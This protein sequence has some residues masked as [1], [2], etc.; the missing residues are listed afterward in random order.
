M[1]NKMKRIS[2]P[3]SSVVGFPTLA[4]FVGILI[5]FQVSFAE[6]ACVICHTEMTPE[7]VEAFLAEDVH[8]GE[9]SCAGCHG[10]NPDA[11]P[12]D[13]DA[14]HEVDSFKAPPWS[15]QT[16][17]DRCG[18]CHTVELDTYMTGP[19]GKAL[20][21]GKN[22]LPGCIGCHTQHPLHKVNGKNSPVQPSRVPQTCGKCHADQVMMTAHDLPF[23]VVR[24]YRNSV[25][26]NALLDQ[27]NSEAP[28]C[29]GCHDNH[30]I[31]HENVSTFDEAC[32]RCHTFEAD[33]FK[34]SKHQRIWELTEAPVCI[35]CHGNHDINKAGTHM[36]GTEESAVCSKCHNPGDPPDE[37]RNLLNSLEEEFARGQTVITK[38]HKAHRNVDNEIEALKA[39]YEQ[40]VKA[41]KSVH[42]F[43]IKRI[44]REVEKGLELSKKV[45]LSIE[46]LLTESSCVTCHTELDDEMIHS[47]DGD[48]HSDKDISCHGCHG[49]NPLIEDEDAMSE[50]E[51][52]I[53]IPERPGDVGKFCSRCHSDPE[54]MGKFNPSIGTDQYAQFQKSGHGQTLKRNPHDKNVANCLKCHGLH[55]I[56]SVNDPLSKVYPTNVPETC[57]Q[58]H[59]N[60]EIMNQ[61]GIHIDP[62]QEYKTSVHG[63]A[64]L[65]NGDI[66][67][68]ACNDCH[69]NHGALPP[70]VGSVSNVCGQCHVINATMFKE[71]IHRGI[72]ELRGMQQCSSC[73]GS[74]AIFHPTDEMLSTKDGSFCSTCH[75]TGGPPDQ[76]HH[77][78]DTLSTS[79]KMAEGKLKLAE[80]YLIGV[81][82][83]YVM[84]DKAKTEL[85]K[86]RVL[87]HNFDMDTLNAVSANTMEIINDVNETGDEG[88]LKAKYRRRGFWIAFVIFIS[89]NIAIILKIRELNKKRKN[90]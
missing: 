83:G 86:M 64:L 17:V 34:S 5:L 33:A 52:F 13:M 21:E 57:N 1:E 62:Y 4:I 60:S 82:E 81:D 79:I 42:Y 6:D 80:S 9:Q 7:I 18:K 78:L 40:L 44:R 41:R 75:Q 47:F 85:T 15:I 88:I 20:A 43:D 16:S 3:G 8:A 84:L 10:G 23:D 65:E 50:D 12:E 11:D 29:T 72:W 37:V 32:G 31:H 48:V 63:E 45:S 51:G 28:S 26:G 39:V 77:L 59:G 14:A 56:R 61:Y 71:S 54:Y 68:P 25:H 27:H 67:A 70:E 38:A 19:H 24:K 73:H 36:I 66:S 55:E 90:N 76:V 87:L 69:G 46:N 53:G 58:C 30:G 74:H 89:F 35:T 2:I 49:G 22:D